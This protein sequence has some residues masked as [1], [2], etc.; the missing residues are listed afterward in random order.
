M[1]ICDDGE[2]VST[3]SNNHVITSQK[4]RSVT[5]IQFGKSFGDGDDRFCPLTAR[6]RSSGG[7]ERW[8]GGAAARAVPPGAPRKA[9]RPPSWRLDDLESKEGDGRGCRSLGDR[10][11]D[12]T[13]AGANA[14]AAAAAQTEEEEERSTS[15]DA[16]SSPGFSLH[17]CQH[18]HSPSHMMKIDY[19]EEMGSPKRLLFK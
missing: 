14:K 8:G 12:S 7:S 9:R 11:N 17:G 2:G 16:S 1:D 13:S 15:S 5:P 3:Q 4:L 18:K 10:V 6:S 19:E